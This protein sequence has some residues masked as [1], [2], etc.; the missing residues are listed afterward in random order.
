M[1]SLVLPS[2]P[3]GDRITVQYDERS[4]TKYFFIRA[5]KE[6]FH[7][8][9]YAPNGVNKGTCPA[10]NI[11]FPFCINAGLFNPRPSTYEPEGII[12]ENG[13]VIQNKPA[14][15]Y[16][17]SMPLTIDKSG[18]LWYAEADVDACALVERGIVSAV[19]GFMPIVIDGKAV[20]PERW[21]KVPHYD[22]PHQRQIIS[23][24]ANGD[25]AIITC[26]GRGYANSPGWTITDAQRIC[27][28]HGLEFAYNLDG[29]TSTELVVDGEQLTSKY[30]RA[31]DRFAPTFIV[32]N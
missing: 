23:Q 24:F 25:Y 10:V 4:E 30:E 18:N 16:P 12:I 6:I 1:R 26:E 21:T 3:V 19:C 31:A 9:V 22:K 11:G 17:D 5:E 32:F 15:F 28:E 13:I 14:A 2:K 29:G 8:F 7:P 27:V 20:P